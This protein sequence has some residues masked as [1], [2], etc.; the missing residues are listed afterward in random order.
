MTAKTAVFEEKVDEKQ[1]LQQFL[2]RGQV[3]QLL[4]TLMGL[5]AWQF[6]RETRA[7]KWVTDGHL[8]TRF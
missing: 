3:G 5:K 7:R 1:Q 8:T 2:T 6:W 4:V